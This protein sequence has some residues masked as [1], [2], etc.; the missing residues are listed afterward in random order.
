MLSDDDHSFGNILLRNLAH[1]SRVFLMHLPSQGPRC[2]PAGVASVMEIS[3]LPPF[4]APQRNIP[5]VYANNDIPAVIH[6]MVNRFVHSHQV[7][8]YKVRGLVRVLPFTI[9]DMPGPGERGPL[10]EVE[11][12]KL[13]WIE[14]LHEM[15]HL[16]TR[17]LSI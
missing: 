8:L 6:G 1:H 13:V 9:E 17:N 5:T 4:V 16:I 15:F 10:L 7:L 2:A 3:P 11:S 12:T 14:V